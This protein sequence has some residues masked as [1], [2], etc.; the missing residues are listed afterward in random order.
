MPDHP[1]EQASTQ[2]S[3]DQPRIW[4][5]D[6]D[7][8]AAIIDGKVRQAVNTQSTARF[9]IDPGALPS[10]VVDLGGPITIRSPDGEI[11]IFSGEVVSARISGS[12]IEIDAQNALEFSDAIVSGFVSWNLPTTESIYTLVRTSGLDD[13]KI[14]IEGLTGQPE[15]FEVVFPVSNIKTHGRRQVGESLILDRLEIEPLTAKLSSQG[16]GKSDIV[17]D[18]FRYSAYILI[19]VTANY[20]IDAEAIAWKQARSTI[21][22]LCIDSRS[23]TVLGPG[24]R[25]STYSRGQSRTVPEAVP[26]SYLRGAA[27]QRAWIRDMS[28]TRKY[29]DLNLRDTPRAWPS[30]RLSELPESISNASLSLYRAISAQDSL[31]ANLAVWDSVEFYC[32]NVRSHRLFSKAEGRSLWKIV[33]KTAT[34]SAEQEERIKSVRD[35]LNDRPLMWK[36]RQQLLADD[37]P[38]TDQEFDAFA[39]LRKNRNGL[40]HGQSSNSAEDEDLRSA[41][42]VMARALTWAGRRLPPA[43]GGATVQAILRAAPDND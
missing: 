25:L 10:G 41:I 36:L 5:A 24:A 31:T 22:W 16:S 40:V 32:S 14:M 34:W 38:F 35:M 19:G 1:Y 15:Y 9:R 43:D 4:L 2:Q 8:S 28:V 13:S 42:R 20:A 39:R 29:G 6:I 17:D 18:F 7:I 27:T 11:L 12:A 26:L 30:Q 21:A 33:T 3:R 37:V 23:T